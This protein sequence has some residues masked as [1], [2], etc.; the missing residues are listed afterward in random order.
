MGWSEGSE[1]AKRFIAVAQKYIPDD[2]RL[3]VY[4]E[5]IKFLCSMDWDTER[6]VLGIDPLFDKAIREIYEEN[7]WRL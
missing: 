3:M 4:K 1:F 6:E 5:Y 7:G 2:E